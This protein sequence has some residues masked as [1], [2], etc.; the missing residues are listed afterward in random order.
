MQKAGL[1]CRLASPF[2][3]VE[4]IDDTTMQVNLADGSTIQANTV[5]SALGR[6][7]NVEPLELDKAG[8]EVV[9]GAIK[10]DDY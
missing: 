5:L 7:P 3:S 6:P 10:V 8:V 9:N 4:K 1:D 2:N